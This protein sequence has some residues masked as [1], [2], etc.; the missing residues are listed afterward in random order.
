MLLIIDGYNVMHS[1]DREWPGARFQDRRR[2]FL[3]RLDAYGAGRPHRITVV[4]D[5]AKGGDGMGGAE[6]VGSVEVR[7][8]ARGVEADELIRGMLDATPSPGEVLVVTSDRSVASYARTRG[9]AT[10]RSDELVR[11][12]FAAPPAAGPASGE[13]R[14]KGVLPDPPRRGTPGGRR[15][16]SPGLW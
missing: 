8:S 6:R 5:G 10:A 16:G 4:F 13:H 3:E 11:R 2:G 9:A 14:L 1:G 15:G 12:L 7:Y